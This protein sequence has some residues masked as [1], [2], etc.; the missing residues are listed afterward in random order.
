MPLDCPLPRVCFPLLLPLPLLLFLLD[1]LEALED[2]AL[3]ADWRDLCEPRL[4]CLLLIDVLEPDLP[5]SLSLDPMGLDLGL[6]TVEP[7]EILYFFAKSGCCLT[8]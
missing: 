5:R 2:L 4:D 1:A 3:F 7:T 6:D 8:K